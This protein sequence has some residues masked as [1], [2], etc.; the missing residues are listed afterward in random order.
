M[1]L[2]DLNSCLTA[3]AR[4]A[5][6][7]TALTLATT[8]AQATNSKSACTTLL[9]RTWGVE[10]EG[11][12]L[13]R[14]G[15]RRFLDRPGFRKTYTLASKD[16]SGDWVPRLIPK[17]IV[18]HRRFKKIIAESNLNLSSDKK[19]TYIFSWMKDRSGVQIR[20][21]NLLSHS[22]AALLIKAIF[23]ARGQ[24]NADTQIRQLD[25]VNPAF[26]ER[27]IEDWRHGRFEGLEWISPDGQPTRPAM[28]AWITNFL[29]QIG[30][31]DESRNDADL[32]MANKI[33]G[34][35]WF[36]PQP[37]THLSEE[38]KA[39]LYSGLRHAYGDLSDFAFLNLLTEIADH[40]FKKFESSIPDS[41]ALRILQKLYSQF[42]IRPLT[43]GMYE[44]LETSHEGIRWKKNKH[45]NFSGE[46][47]NF[48]EALKFGF[49]GLRSKIDGQPQ[50]ARGAW[51]PKIALEM[52]ALSDVS[53]TFIA[54]P[55]N[56]NS[57]MIS[58]RDFDR[59][60]GDAP[61]GTIGEFRELCNSIRK[62]GI[63]PGFIK[64]FEKVTRNRF[65]SL[66]EIVDK[67]QLRA[68]LLFPLTDWENHPR[69]AHAF[70]MMKPEDRQM[71][72]AAITNAR[73]NFVRAINKI[74][75]TFDFS[76]ASD[77]LIIKYITNTE[78]EIFA[79][80]L[81]F[82]H[83]SQ[84]PRLFAASLDLQLEKISTLP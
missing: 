20:N 15:E 66:H 40:I 39:A 6:L 1:S 36:Y 80:A 19:P 26:V 61:R 23:E 68:S 50:L 18:R 47:P 55:G 81:R 28:L 73:Q 56:P 71:T 44:S 34:H 59:F 49:V 38:D 33:R 30:I 13:A 46:D 83:D 22:E 79:A 54:L 37:N 43:R 57:G 16:A 24:D 52:R 27:A 45:G 42:L 5:L 64:I 21:W 29:R 3:S 84:L 48:P 67:S 11:Y 14:L 12:E 8:G 51:I 70:T 10:I 31:I 2:L 77:Q 78:G 32:N 53:N 65:I 25:P 60:A 63:H 69:I 74:M 58:V 7:A 4:M 9:K 62:N 72:A 75:G 35:L 82:A 76:Q 41:E 17:K